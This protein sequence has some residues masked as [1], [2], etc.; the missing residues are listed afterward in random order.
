MSL[1]LYVYVGYYLWLW[2]AAKLYK[3]PIHTHAYSPSISIIIAARNEENVLPRRI[4]NLRR[5]LY[6]PALLQVIIAS[7][8]STDRTSEILLQN[9]DYA[10][11]V[12]LE[13][14][15]G[16]ASALNEAVRLATGE[17][18]VF[19]DVRQIIDPDAIQEL[20][21]PFSDPTV[22]A[23]SGSLLIDD[24]TESGEHVFL[25]KYWHFEKEIRFYESVSG[26]SVGVTGAI[27]AI[28][29]E[30]YTAIP[31]GTLLDDVFIPMHVA[32]K[33]KRVIFQPRAIARDTFSAQ[34]GREF[35]R[36][37]RTLSGNF[38]LLTISPWLISPKNPILFRF[39]SHK[40]LRLLSP[41]LLIVILFT[42]AE[43]DSPFYKAMFAIQVFFYICSAL[44]SAI[45]SLRRSWP[46]AL[47]YTFV[48][49]NLAALIAFLRFA[50]RRRSVWR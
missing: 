21:L 48:T 27:Y 36:K 4:A 10:I 43:S 12:I 47:I 8:G 32:L 31:K 15:E 40:L 29:R 3:R 17:I 41:F 2:L 22:G 39:V 37:I 33:G 7:D 34:K 38:Q 11:P 9:R 30:L 44:T 24:E 49:M 42:S 20:V 23:V 1:L 45:P 25:G 35:A 46:M 13:R 14:H 18:L 16:K 28:R 26:S 50:T 6:D 5:L 19:F